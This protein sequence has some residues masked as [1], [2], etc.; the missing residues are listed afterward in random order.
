V[1]A[2]VENVATPEA[3]NAP[4]PRT[5][6]PSLK[7]TVPVGV[8]G[9]VDVTVAVNVTDW[10]AVDG[11]SEDATAVAV[12]PLTTCVTTEDVLDAK[13]ASPLYVA[14]ME[15]E[16]AVSVLVANVA[17][18]EPFSGP[19]P[20]VVAPSLNVTVPVGVPGDV[21]VTVAVNVTDCPAR[22]GFRLDA[23]A[24]EDGF[25]AEGLTTCETAG[26]TLAACAE[27]PA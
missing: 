20:K 24:V 19:L 7:V 14:V 17:I 6:A 10:P 13:V 8:P 5:V 22:L 27:S 2:L 18:A 9:A 23:S 4:V 3:F 12:V 11:F 15:W 26:E 1:S 25:S 16:P 21:D